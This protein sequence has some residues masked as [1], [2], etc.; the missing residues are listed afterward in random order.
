MR[1]KPCLCGEAGRRLTQLVEEKVRELGLLLREFRVMPDRV[2]ISVSAPPTLAPHRIAC[3]IKAHTSRAL[4]DE[5]VEMTRIPTLW[6]RSYL[7]FGGEHFTPEEALAAFEALQPARRPRG[8][9]RK[10]AVTGE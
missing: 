5:F 2:Y 1:C 7:V 10:T 9:P 6:T 4:R 8:R 3:Q